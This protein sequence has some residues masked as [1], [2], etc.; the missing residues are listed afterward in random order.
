[1]IRSLYKQ[2]ALTLFLLGVMLPGFAQQ[3]IIRGTTYESS[4]GEPLFGV[5][6]LIEGTTNGAVTDFDGKFEI[7]VEPGV[8]NL[9]A[10]FVSFKSVTI[11]ELE[12]NPDKVTLIDAIWMEDAVEELEAVIV[13][14][15]VIKSSESALLTV[16]RKSANVLDG[17]SATAFRKIGDS[18]AASASKRITGVSIEGGK[19]VFVR[20]L[21]DRY[22]KSILNGM[23]IPGLDPDRNT[24]QM[25]IFPTN[26]LDNIIV[27]KSFT[28]DLPAD[29]TGG[30]V[31]I[32]TKDFPEER[33]LDA[34]VSLGYNPSMHFNGDYLTY[35][36]SSTDWLGFDNGDRDIPTGDRNDIP[37]F[38][39]VVAGGPSDPVVQDYESILRSFDQTLGAMQQNSGANFGISASY[40]DQVALKKLTLGY[41][42][43]LSYKNETE[44]FQDAEFSRFGKAPDL[45]QTQLDTLEFQKGDFGVNNVLIGGLAGIAVKTDKAKYKL[46]FLHLQNGESKAGT[47]TYLG[48]ELGSVFDALQYN[49]EYGERSLTNFL[50]GGE[51]FNADG[52]WQLEWKISPTRSKITDP[53]IRFTRLRTDRSGSLVGT[54]SGLPERIWRFLEEDNLAGRLDITRK[55]QFL[56]NESKLKF[57]A[58]YTY[59]ERDYDIRSFQFATNRFQVTDTD[60]NN[61]LA[62]ENLWNAADRE[63]VIYNPLFIPRNTNEFNS[64]MDIFGAYVSNEF[65]PT[66]SLKAIVGLRMENY[67]QRYT[68]EDQSQ[69]NVLNDSIVVEDLNLFPSV[70][71]IYSVTE[72]QNIRFSY[73]RT[74]A[75]PSFKEASFAEILDP[76]TGR[77]FIGGFFPDTDNELG[78]VWDGN[79]QVSL[80]N[81]FDI[82]WELFQDRGQ[83]ISVSG[84]FKTFKDPIELVQFNSAPNNFQPRNVGD[85]RV[86]GGEFEVRQSLDFISPNL[87][88]FSFIGNLTVTNSRIEMSPSEFQSRV[89]SARTGENVDDDTREMAGQAPWIVNAGIGYAGL[90]NGLEAGLYYNVRG[91]TLYAVGVRNVPDIFTVPFH[92]LNFNA[93]YA[94]GFEDRMRLGFKIDN[95]LNDKQEQIYKNFQATD[96]IFTRLAPRTE[97]SVSFKYSFF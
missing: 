94:F 19:Y 36:G 91:E 18:D 35:D 97:I 58:S 87:T 83:T 85:G 61:F 37:Q 92:S 49:L 48:R 73:S 1:M 46:N 90:D 25:D 39:D 7:K 57:G 28:A 88:D 72:R 17:I 67:T 10:S 41:N 95:I 52:T 22:T 76:I 77:T 6:V 20:G 84:F 65:Q 55:Y 78:V 79:L 14:A 23:D 93:N 33:V 44:F 74:T 51:H 40:G 60:P 53:D 69:T 2:A 9:S 32:E 8:Y 47:F 30:I 12:V 63:G 89:L 81:N 50:L 27:L 42:V 54:E 59:K 24:L 56:G 86:I 34:S 68:G 26:V 71:L 80:I 5:T 64:T 11:S 43:A 16:K 29:F 75:R 21:G 45:N 13:T 38:S 70:N 62:E 96:R 82:R 3:G 31:N 4:S 15:E 66:E